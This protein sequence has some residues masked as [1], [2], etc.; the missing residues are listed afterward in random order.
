MSLP[1][2]F[3]TA[4]RLEVKVAYNW[5]ESQRRGLGSR[6]LNAVQKTLNSIGDNPYRYGFAQGDIR[7]GLVKRYPFA[8]YYRVLPDRI[9]ILAIHHT[10]RDP[11]IWEDRI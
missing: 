8:I 11:A 10:S 2:D 3:N 5:Y 9:R 6:F 1:L 7:E 4:T